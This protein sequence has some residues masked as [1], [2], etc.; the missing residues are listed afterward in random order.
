MKALILL[1]LV[2][3]SSFGGPF[4]PNGYPPKLEI[5]KTLKIRLDMYESCDTVALHLETK[6]A[7][8]LAD[9]GMLITKVTLGPCE[10]LAPRKVINDTLPVTRETTVEY[11]KP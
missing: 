1:S 10:Y 9:D 2:S 7:E 8:A 11:T 5:V 6:V 4:S 3:I